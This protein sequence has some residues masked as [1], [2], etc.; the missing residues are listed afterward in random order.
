VKPH[1]P[2]NEQQGKDDKDKK[3]AEHR[4]FF[5]IGIGHMIE[6]QQRQSTRL[7]HREKNTVG[8]SLMAEIKTMMATETWSAS[9]LAEE[10]GENNRTG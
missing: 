2:A 8:I 9:T 1:K 3:D 5:G 7:V 4:C 6:H 10:C